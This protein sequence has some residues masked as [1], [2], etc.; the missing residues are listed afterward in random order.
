MAR[1]RFPGWYT[2]ED[3]YR[4]WYSFKLK[5]HELHCEVLRHGKLV[6]FEPTEQA[7]NFPKKF[8]KKVLTN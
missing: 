1:K 5:G 3:G 2:F 6:R 7:Q 8:L 4:C